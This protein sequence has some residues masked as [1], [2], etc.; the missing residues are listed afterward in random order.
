[1][2]TYPTVTSQDSYLQALKDMNNGVKGAREAVIAAQ[3]DPLVPLG[4]LYICNIAIAPTFSVDSWLHTPMLL[5]EP[6]PSETALRL[7]Q[8]DD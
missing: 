8:E 4:G 5:D 2:M 1:M 3:H 6:S 7:S